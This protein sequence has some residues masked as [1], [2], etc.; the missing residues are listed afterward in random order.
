MSRLL[1]NEN[2]MM[3]LPNLAEKIGLNEAVVL[4]QLHYLMNPEFNKNFINGRYWVYN[5]YEQW[6]KKFKFWSVPTVKR[7]FLNLEENGLVLTDRF[8]EDS[9]V[10]T[11]WYTIDYESL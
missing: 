2:P 11:K 10:R 3:I 5:T 6:Q 8:N 1:I 9:H 4:Q 7:I